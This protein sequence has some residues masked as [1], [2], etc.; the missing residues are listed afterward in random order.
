MPQAHTNH[1]VAETF[2]FN[3][4]LGSHWPPSREAMARAEQVAVELGLAPLL[5]A[6]PAGMNQVVG[7]NGW[8]LCAGERARVFLA[9]GLLQ[10]PGLLVVDEVLAPLDPHTAHRVLDT[11]D[12]RA[13][14]LLLIT[15]E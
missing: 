10:N 15:H 6:M 3:L 4:L 1:I 12:Q 9:R 11:M 5:Q 13:R 8:R 7:D 14:K 2:A